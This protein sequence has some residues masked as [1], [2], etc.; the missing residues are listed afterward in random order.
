[1]SHYEKELWATPSKRESAV[2]YVIPDA[3]GLVCIVARPIALSERQPVDSEK[4]EYGQCYYGNWFRG[5]W[6]WTLVSIP[7]GW[8]THFLPAGVEV[9]PATCFAP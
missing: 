6:S 5:S 7:G 8:N 2:D 1:M 3:T 4:N 9:L